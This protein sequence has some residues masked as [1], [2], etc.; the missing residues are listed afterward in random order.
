VPEE[1]TGSVPLDSALPP[2]PIDKDSVRSLSSTRRRPVPPPKEKRRSRPSMLH[3]S[4][5]Q[6][7]LASHSSGLFRRRTGRRN[8][9]SFISQLASLKHWI[10][11]SAKRA[12]SP[13][14]RTPKS[15]NG[16]TLKFR[17]DKSSPGKSQDSNK[18]PGGGSSTNTHASVVTPTQVKRSSNASSLAPNSVSY[19]QHRNSYGRQ[20]RTN[21]NSLSPTPITPRGS[22]YRRSSVG[23]RGRKSTSSSISSVRS[24]HHAHTHSKASSISSNSI[25][26]LSTPTVSNRVSRSPHTSVKVLP[27]TPIAAARFPNNIRLVRS[28]AHGLR[29]VN[30][31]ENHG[32]Y[33]VFNETAPG[34]MMSSP[35]GFVFARRKRTPFKGPMVHTGNT[36]VSNGF[37]TPNLSPPFLKGVGVQDTAKP[38]TRKSQIIEEGDEIEE[39]DIEEVDTFSNPDIADEKIEPFIEPIEEKLHIET[40]FAEKAEASSS[41]KPV[42]Q[43]APDLPSPGVHPPRSSSLNTPDLQEVGEEEKEENSRDDST[44]ILPSA[45][46]DKEPTNPSTTATITEEEDHTLQPNPKDSALDTPT[47][48]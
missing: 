25:D 39:E 45:H 41:S 34:P 19:A 13:H 1:F 36:V 37:A 21:R 18:T 7:E 33:S 32:I 38:A 23:L 10:V 44:A 2:R 48:Q 14:P 43:P 22:S 27:A 8:H 28:A 15:G 6:P 20:P 9:H 31:P 16:Q 30:E 35:S 17:V 40:A 5:S 42:L 11:E 3:V 24:I 4:A 26:T 47:A 46:V 29:D 12:K